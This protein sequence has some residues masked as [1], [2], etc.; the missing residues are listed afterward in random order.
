MADKNF[1]QYREEVLIEPIRSEF[2]LRPRSGVGQDSNASLRERVTSIQPLRAKETARKGPLDINSDRAKKHSTSRKTVIAA[3]W[4]SKPIS[5]QIDEKART[6]KVSRSKAIHMLIERGLKNDILSDYEAILK[7]TI[8][9]AVQR[10]Y[11]KTS[12]RQTNVLYRSY[13]LTA[14]NLH[15]LI[16]LLSRI[17]SAKR[18]TP[19]Q[20]DNVIA[21]SRQEAG[22]H[23]ARRDE[24][25]HQAISDWL[26]RDHEPSRDA[27]PSPQEAVEER[28]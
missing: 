17:G 1:P 11:R 19:E 4:V 27:E 2:S 6:W 23:V 16:N 22:E 7:D 14:Q 21:W 24:P 12:E 15:L 5:S 18:L 3:G 25:L 13:T 8:E 20:L 10:A 28:A 9:R 26:A